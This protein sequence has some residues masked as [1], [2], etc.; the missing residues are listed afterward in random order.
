MCSGGTFSDRSEGVCV[1]LLDVPPH[2]I[3]RFRRFAPTGVSPASPDQGGS[4][5]TGDYSQLHAPPWK[6]LHMRSCEV[7]CTEPSYWLIREVRRRPAE[8]WAWAEAR[9]SFARA[10]W[11]VRLRLLDILVLFR[12]DGRFDLEPSQ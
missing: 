4:D 3:R 7:V 12:V 2:L 10:R 6:A 9:R 11:W 1:A 8:A 5:Q